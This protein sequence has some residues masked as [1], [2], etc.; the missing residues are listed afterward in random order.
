LFDFFS[1]VESKEAKYNLLA[2]ALKFLQVTCQPKPTWTK[3]KRVYD[4]LR[5]LKRNKNKDSLK[6]FLSD[7]FDALPL[8]APT[9][10]VSNPLVKKPNE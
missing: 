1:G 7:K 8:S 10:R 9:L 2:S 6:T 4:S 3:A 5:G